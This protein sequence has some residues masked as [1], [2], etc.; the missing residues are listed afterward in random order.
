MLLSI[1]EW[2]L[3][4]FVQNYYSAAL[5]LLKWIIQLNICLNKTLKVL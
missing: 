1:M 3:I 2:K 5:K 4:Q